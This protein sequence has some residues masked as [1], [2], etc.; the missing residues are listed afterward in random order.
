[1]IDTNLFHL[2]LLMWM[3]LFHCIDVVDC[4]ILTGQSGRS[5]YRFNSRLTFNWQWCRLLLDLIKTRLLLQHDRIKLV[6]IDEPTLRPTRSSS[7]YYFADTMRLIGERDLAAMIVKGIG[8]FPE[9][10]DRLGGTID[11]WWIVRILRDDWEQNNISG[12]EQ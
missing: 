2:N 8:Q 5:W 1:M 10:G 3:F 12:W 6:G 7:V 9:N 4:M 11:I